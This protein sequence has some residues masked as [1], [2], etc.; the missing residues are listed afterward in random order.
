MTGRY[1]R[2]VRAAGAVDAGSFPPRSERNRQPAVIPLRNVL[3]DALLQR[4]LE[5]FART[6]WKD[7][8]NASVRIDRV[9]MRGT[10]PVAISVD[11]DR[12][13]RASELLWEYRLANVEPYAPVLVRSR[14]AT[15]WRL[16]LPPIVESHGDGRTAPTWRVG[17]FD[18]SGERIFLT[19]FVSV[20]DCARLA[21]E[22]L[23]GGTTARGSAAT[24]FPVRRGLAS[25]GATAVRADRRPAPTR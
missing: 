3:G 8:K 14:S 25:N 10:T 15:S 20:E 11:A 17:A 22:I 6:L 24:P 12:L 19:E 18:T 23:S 21:K 2:P 16:L 5:A 1:M 4:L 7:Y 13:W 9:P